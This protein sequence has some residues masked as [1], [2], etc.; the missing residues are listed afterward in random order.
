MHTATQLNNENVLCK[1]LYEFEAKMICI[2]GNGGGGGAGYAYVVL[3]HQ[4][5]NK[6]VCV[7]MSM[8]MLCILPPS[9]L[10]QRAT[11]QYTYIHVCVCVYMLQPFPRSPYRAY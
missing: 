2:D 5:L 8:G 11:I 4:Q 9:L 3:Y 7:H 10:L 6:A 1:L